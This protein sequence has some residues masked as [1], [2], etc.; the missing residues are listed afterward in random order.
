MKAQDHFS[1]DAQDMYTGV[2]DAVLREDLNAKVASALEALA[3]GAE[4]GRDQAS[5]LATFKQHLEDIDRDMLETEDAERVALVFERMLD[6]LG[7]ESS[8]GVLNTWLY[9]FD[10]SE[11]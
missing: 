1:A 11:T 7:I 10:P 5:L 8:E 9:G 3:I 2:Q 4:Q 6:V